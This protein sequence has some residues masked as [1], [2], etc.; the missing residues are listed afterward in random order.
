LFGSNKEY[1]EIKSISMYN[2]RK[3]L[4]HLAVISSSAIL[5]YGLIYPLIFGMSGY[6]DDDDDDYSSDD[7][8]FDFGED[9]EGLSH[10]PS[11]SWKGTAKRIL[12]GLAVAQ[13]G[14]T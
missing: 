1:K 13:E 5:L 2:F 8:S 6:D 12:L 9:A 14:A 4:A 3:S 10:S 7:F 11:W